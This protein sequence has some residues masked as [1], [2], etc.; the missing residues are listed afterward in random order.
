MRIARAGDQN[1]DNQGRFSQFLQQLGDGTFPVH[2]GVGEFSIKI[3]PAYD[4][5]PDLHHLMAKVFDVIQQRYRN[6]DWLCGRTIITGTNHSVEEIIMPRLYSG[7]LA[8]NVS[9][10]AMTRCEMRQ[11]NLSILP[12]LFTPSTRQACLLTAWH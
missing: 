6:S 8:R 11:M 1:E 4:A 10:S 5:G 12:S 7:F 9:T 2:Q 3:P